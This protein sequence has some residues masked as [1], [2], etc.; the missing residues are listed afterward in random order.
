MESTPN[1][2]SRLT[3]EINKENRV[4]IDAWNHRLNCVPP[5]QKLS[6]NKVGADIEITTEILVT[7]DVWNRQHD[8]RVKL[9]AKID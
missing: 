5:S 9:I 3:H 6:E 4:I 7:A 1:T 8:L 2:N